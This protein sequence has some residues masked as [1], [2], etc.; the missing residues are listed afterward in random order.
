[1]WGVCC[2]VLDSRQD[3][4]D[5]FQATFLV[6][7]RKAASVVTV[8]SWLYGVAHRTALKARTM[9]ARRRAREKQMTDALEPAHE[10]RETSRLHELL[11][12]ELTR[13][14]GKYRDVIVICDLQGKT[15]KEAARLFAVPEGTVA[16]R[17]AV[18]RTMLAKRLTRHGVALSGATLAALLADNVLSA[19]VPATVTA[20][21]IEAAGLFAAGQAALGGALSARAVVLTERVLR[22]MLLSRLKA[23]AALC[24]LLATLA[25]GAAALVHSTRSDKPAAQPLQAAGEGL[26]DSRALDWSQW[27]GPGRDGVVQGV[28][29]PE[30]WPAALQAEWA[31]AV[32]P[33]V[34]S[35]VVAGGKIFVFTRQQEDELVLCLDLARGQE[36][37]RSQPC[38]APY[39][40][41]SEE[42]NFSIGPRSTPALAL[43]RIYTLGMGRSLSCLDETTGRLL[44]RR[45]CKSSVPAAHNYGG[46]SPLVVDGLC[47]VHGGDGK[48]GGLTAFDARTGEPRWCF[49]DG[50]E[51]M[52][53]SPMLVDL[54]GQRQLV[55]YAAS[56]PAG[57]ALATGQKLWGVG[58][59]AV[60]PPHTTPVQYQ[61]L[62]ILNDVIQPP[63]ALRL[64]NRQG[65]I[66]AQEVW[67]A[68]TGPIACC[69]PVIVGDLLFGM[70][71]RKNGCF[72]CL[73]ARTG[74]LL[75]ETEGRDGDHASI[76]SAGSVLLILT[77][78]GR[79]IVVKPSAAAFEPIAE[80]HVSDTDTYAHPI[81]LG[82]RILVR[83]ATVLRSFRIEPDGGK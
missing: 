33:G 67:K 69:S 26:Q 20:S 2:R 34:A 37:W 49:A 10:P 25:G 6:L 74:A 54:A 14:P 22:S 31:V 47:I 80:Y 59:G 45:D 63:R 75:W 18:A 40:P 28:K 81:F 9:A 65:T 70:S 53:G 30:R 73:D 32:G 46:T 78:K 71:S 60:G 50:Y 44:W 76:V 48:T 72:F 19:A 66:V 41:S 62:V 43:G 42:R 7:V 17:L 79:L 29:V 11:D 21:T 56:Q 24:V 27:R 36:L 16:S 23:G 1:M 8:G 57:V 58:A 35:P 3:A 82:E 12:Q 52:S 61:D 55:T 68:K 4:E 51:P 5:A 39:K 83:D 15:R 64:D 38:Q 13:L 77:D